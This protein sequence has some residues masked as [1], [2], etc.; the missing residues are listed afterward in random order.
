MQS[1][2]RQELDIKSALDIVDGNATNYR[3]SKHIDIRYH[4]IGHYLRDNK[5]SVHYIP[6][7]KQ[8]ADIFTNGTQTS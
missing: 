8:I 3:K 2:D 1:Q 6:G 4:A 5:I 7:S